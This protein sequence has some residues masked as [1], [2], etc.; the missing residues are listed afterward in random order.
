MKN[1]TSFLILFV[2]IGTLSGF[3]EMFLVR[4][5]KEKGQIYYKWVLPIVLL[6][7]FLMLL[8]TLF[9]YFA[10]KREINFVV[11][12]S[13]LSLLI[14][15]S[16]LKHWAIESLGKY[17]S[18]QVEIRKNHQLIKTGAY[19]YSRHPGYLSTIFDMIII[20][21]V[22]NAFYTLI[23][24]L[25]AYL[26]LLYIRIS[27]EEKALIEKFGEEYIKYQKETWTLIPYVY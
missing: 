26:I 24:I 17:W 23:W 13:G 2:V 20:P 6:L 16:L 8:S 22:A 10:V 5:K 4:G 15:R 18:V 14:G 11:V 3:V 12:W 1:F 27:T 21:I 9:E 19:K 25:I 7:Y